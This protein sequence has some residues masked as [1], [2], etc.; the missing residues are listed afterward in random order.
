MT[1]ETVVP[2]EQ[3]RAEVNGWL[4]HK[5]IDADTRNAQSA[6][7]EKLA[8]YV[9]EGKIV[10]GDD[11]K[12]VVT[13]NF[14]IEVAS[15]EIPTLTFK[16]RVTVGET[17]DKLAAVGVGDFDGKCMAYVQAATGMQQQVLDGLDSTD[18][19]LCSLIALFF[20]V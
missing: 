20:M 14:P 5:K 8:K 2:I 19:A 17:K 18:A 3:A 12:M 7:I 15:K 10:I 1:N 11:K 16:P 6:A 9:S 13:L 4:D